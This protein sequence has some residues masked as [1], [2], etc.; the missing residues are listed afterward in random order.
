M[1]AASGATVPRE[2]MTQEPQISLGDGWSAL[3]TFRQ[4]GPPEAPDDDGTKG[5]GGDADPDP[6]PSSGG[7]A[8]AHSH[9]GLRS[10]AS[11]Q[12]NDRG[13]LTG[14]TA[15]ELR[16]RHDGVW[17]PSAETHG[18]RRAIA[19]P[20]GVASRQPGEPVPRPATQSVLAN[21]PGIAAR[22]ADTVDRG[23]TDAAPG[24]PDRTG[25]VA[26]P[27]GALGQGVGRGMSLKLAPG[28]LD[29]ASELA[30]SVLTPEMG[31]ASVEHVATARTRPPEVAEEPDGLP[32]LA[33]PAAQ[34]HGAESSARLNNAMRAAVP[35]IAA[36]IATQTRNG[37][38][39]FELRLEPPELG[40]IEVT[41]DFRRDGSMAAKLVVERPETLDFLMRDARAL[42]KTL[43]ANGLK[44]EDGA[45]QYQLKDQSTS[46]RH[47][48]P[49]VHPETG[50]KE[51]TSDNIETDDGTG[52]VRTWRAVPSGIDIR[53]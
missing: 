34:A 7:P 50:A 49:R 8:F 36:E 46:G 39:S 25:T 27:G 21:A 19:L 53:V 47:D 48:R 45:I 30:R 41:L 26:E 5:N 29:G 15:V 51:G 3:A 10:P 14:L 32:R 17:Q 52:G 6:V 37:S 43:Q 18:A 1:P 42:E 40:R 23:R 4:I 11:S 20:G 9:D 24:S 33:L 2:G 35:V 22:V 31:G 44:L 13:G 38:R 12:E 16:G 28:R